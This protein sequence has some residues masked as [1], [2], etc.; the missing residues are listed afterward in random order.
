GPERCSPSATP[1]SRRSRAPTRRPRGSVF[2]RPPPA[3]SSDPRIHSRRVPPSHCMTGQPT[4]RTDAQLLQAAAEDSFP[5][6]DPRHAP[7]PCTWLRGRAGSAAPDLTA[8][9][10]AQAWIS[11]RRFR[12]DCDGSALPWLHG[13]ARNVLR[14]SARR[15]RVETRARERLG[16]PLDLAAEDGY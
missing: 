14:E 12:D 8:E 13:I 15:D 7:A 1:A 4:A 9:T 16:L 11:K 5:E 3:P 10:F 6:L 2:A